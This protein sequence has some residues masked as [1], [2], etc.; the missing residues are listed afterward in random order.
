MLFRGN[1]EVLLVG[2]CLSSHRL[3]GV[4]AVICESRQFLH[5][6]FRGNDEESVGLF[7]FFTRS[8]AGSRPAKTARTPARQR[9]P[10]GRPLDPLPPAETRPE[11]APRTPLATPPPRAPC[12]RPATTTPCGERSKSPSDAS[13]K[14][15]VEKGRAFPGAAT[16]PLHWRRHG[17]ELSNDACFPAKAVYYPRCSANRRLRF[18]KRSVLT[19]PP[20]VPVSKRSRHEHTARYSRCACRE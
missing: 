8:N 3:F 10:S 2:Y 19:R 14:A 1:D 5:A 13:S 9:L 18:G 12:A 20:R 6:L 11:R 16:A 15:L 4:P 7:D 17:R